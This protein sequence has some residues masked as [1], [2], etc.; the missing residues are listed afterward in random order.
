MGNNTC[1]VSKLSN[2][3]DNW[4]SERRKVQESGDSEKVE[5]VMR[6]DA[7]SDKLILLCWKGC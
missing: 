1:W 5:K 2:S 6:M 7:D 4:E 3:I